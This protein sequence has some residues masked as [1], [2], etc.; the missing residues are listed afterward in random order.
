VAGAIFSGFAMVVTLMVPARAY[1][2]L[3]DLITVRHLDN[4]NKIIL[5]TSCMVGYAYGV[6]WFIAW[7]S[8]SPYEHFVFVNRATGPYAWCYWVMVLCNA[9]VP[10][11]FWFKRWRT[12]PWMM[13]IVAVL[14]NVGMWMERFVIIVVSLS[15]EFVPSSWGDF[16][17]TWVD[18]CMF[19]GSF[20][21]FLMMFLLFCRFLP[22][23][24]A[25]EVKA[26]LPGAHGE[27]H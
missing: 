19:L 15:R 13:L 1:F 11:L 3:K 4:M 20:G 8:G 22:M 26:V 17:P 16:M 27:H 21:L 9:V 5:A 14:V 2:G 23:V 24:A 12:T 7:Y 10:H 6:E 18:V 25:A